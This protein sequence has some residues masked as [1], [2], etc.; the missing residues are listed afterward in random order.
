MIPQGKSK[1]A[2]SG[3]Q[4]LAVFLKLL[5]RS[6]FTLGMLGLFPNLQTPAHLKYH[7]SF[8]TDCNKLVLRKISSVLGHGMQP[9]PSE[10]RQ[11]TATTRQGEK[12]KLKYVYSQLASSLT[13]LQNFLVALW[14]LTRG[15]QVRHSSSLPE[16]APAALPSCREAAGRDL[17]PPIAGRNSRALLT[18]LWNHSP[19]ARTAASCLLWHRAVCQLC[20]AAG[21]RL[22]LRVRVHAGA[23]CHA[24]LL[25]PFLKPVCLKV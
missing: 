3:P 6:G 8:G 19:F 4:H 25:C 24:H 18:W 15:K 9:E 7:S 21:S 17:G 12:H 23:P 13:S 2:L 20:P 10:S 1:R 11:R 14:L 5:F 16:G 22:S